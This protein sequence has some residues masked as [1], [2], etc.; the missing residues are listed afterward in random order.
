MSRK[1]DPAD[2][3]TVIDPRLEPDTGPLQSLSSLT[4]QTGKAAS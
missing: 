1:P 4:P 3:V 2:Y